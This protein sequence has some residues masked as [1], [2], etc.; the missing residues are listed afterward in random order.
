MC[1]TIKIEV[2]IL[3]IVFGV[4]A[5]SAKEHGQ[6]FNAELVSVLEEYFILP[7]EVREAGADIAELKSQLQQLKEETSDFEAEITRRINLLFHL[8]T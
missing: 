6:S 3:E 7:E 4:L 1:D 8:S 5:E 2:E